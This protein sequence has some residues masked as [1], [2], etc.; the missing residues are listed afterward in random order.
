[1]R[2]HCNFATALALMHLRLHRP[3]LAG[4]RSAGPHRREH[5]VR[6]RHAAYLVEGV[7]RLSR[8]ML[9]LEVPLQ[10]CP[11][12]RRESSV[13]VSWVVRARPKAERA[14][15]R[16]HAQPVEG[17]VEI[18]HEVLLPNDLRHMRTCTC[19]HRLTQRH[20]RST[21][22]GREQHGGS[23]RGDRLNEGPSA[24]VSVRVRV[25]VRVPDV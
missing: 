2:T 8:K 22:A 24:S 1:M 12:T 6:V 13:V 5:R 10:E 18:L 19:W 16:R 11:P 9:L 14:C 21:T 7:C 25:R 17:G 4:L 15:A 23:M 3:H 20:G